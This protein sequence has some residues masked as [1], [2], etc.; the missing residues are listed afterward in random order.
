MPT[1]PLYIPPTNAD[2]WHRV[3]APGGYEWWYFD[4]EDATDD[5]QIVGILFEGFVFHPEYLRRYAR[6]RRRPT[7][8]APP[9]PA[10]YPCAYLV[11]YRGGQIA[12]QCM[13]QYAPA[14]YQASDAGLDVRIGPN[15]LRREADGSLRLHLEGVP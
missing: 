11:V 7:R 2:A 6:Y 12:W 13:M 5:V 3:T 9:L 4:A 8:V 10:E 1:L 15:S 14:D